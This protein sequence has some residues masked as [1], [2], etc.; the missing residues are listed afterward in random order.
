MAQLK[1][2]PV[3][4]IQLVEDYSHIQAVPDTWAQTLGLTAK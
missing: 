1:A 4:T 3:G 2:T